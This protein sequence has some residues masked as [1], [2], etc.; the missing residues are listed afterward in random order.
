VLTDK[1]MRLWATP[2]NLAAH[3]ARQCLPEH[4]KPA[5]IVGATLFLASRVSRM[6]TGQTMAVDG[7]VVVSG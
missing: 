1:Q 2:E 6:M 5:D 3:L 7:G 4:L